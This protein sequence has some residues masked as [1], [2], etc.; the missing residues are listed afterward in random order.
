MPF[1]LDTSIAVSWGFDDEVSPYADRVLDLLDG[2]TALVPAIWPLEV[3]NA[4]LMG[5]RRGRLQTADTVRLTELLRALPITV[6]AADSQRALNAVL[7]MA[8]T[9][10]LT[11]YDASYL[12]LA[13]RE[14]I[15]IATE[16]AKLTNAATRC[17]VPIVSESE[18]RP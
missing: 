5:E 8:R 2:D 4:L 18:E 13:M 3:A 1:V 14:G 6:D 7:N 9:Y 10:S 16:D 12:E 17:G 15:A 11:S